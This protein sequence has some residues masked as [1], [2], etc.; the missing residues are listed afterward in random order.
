MKQRLTVLAM[1]LAL[2]S[3]L[4]IAPLSAAAAPS[5]TPAP[6]P[7][8]AVTGLPISGT[9]PGVSSFVGTLDITRFAVQNGQLVAIGTISG[10]LTNLVTGAVQTVT[11]VPVT[12]PVTTITGSCQ[13]L[14]L[15]LGPLDLNLLGLQ[16]HLDRVVLDITAQSGPGNLLGNLLCGIAG[17][18]DSNGP[19]TSIARL[20]NQILSILR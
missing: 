8:A 18:L 2:A 12:L 1:L 14:H 7:A 17:L 10:T 13:I 19:L 5:P 11:N 16:V 3:A 4:L 9:I 20:L 15:E 6:A